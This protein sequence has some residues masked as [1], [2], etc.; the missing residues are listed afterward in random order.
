MVPSGRHFK[1]AATRLPTLKTRSASQPAERKEQVQNDEIFSI[2]VKRQMQMRKDL[3]QLRTPVALPRNK[4]LSSSPQWCAQLPLSDSPGPEIW[5]TMAFTMSTQPVVAL[6]KMDVDP[7]LLAWLLLDFFVVSALPSSLEW[8]IHCMSWIE[9]DGLTVF[10]RLRP[11]KHLSL[12]Q[13][14]FDKGKTANAGL[15]ILEGARLDLSRAGAAASCDGCSASECALRDCRREAGL[16]N[17]SSK[18]PLLRMDDLEVENS[19][20]GR[21]LTGAGVA[22]GGGGAMGGSRCTITCVYA[23]PLIADLPHSNVDFGRD[24]APTE[25][26]PLGWAVGN[27]WV[28]QTVIGTTHFDWWGEERKAYARAMD[29]AIAQ[30][31]PE[32]LKACDGQQAVP[33]SQHWWSSCHSMGFTACRETNL[34]GKCCCPTGQRVGEDGCKSCGVLEERLSALHQLNLLYTLDDP[35]AGQYFFYWM[36]FG[37]LVLLPLPWALLAQVLWQFAEP[38]ESFLQHEAREERKHIA[39]T[40]IGTENLHGPSTIHVANMAGE[41]RAIPGFRE[42]SLLV[43]LRRSVAEVFSVEF[44]EIGL[45]FGGQ[46]LSPDLDFKTLGDLGIYD[47]C[48]VSFIQMGAQAS[49]LSVLPFLETMEV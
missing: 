3:A 37:S 11:E 30:Q 10:M 44:P 8:T 49:V 25:G 18:I 31:L 40:W 45:A 24:T 42:T 38:N 47:G 19:E 6:A 43:H 16:S 14:E 34:A 13:F 7:Y 1:L 9:F 33:D 5:V 48:T 12:A 20:V 21:R 46:L 2:M 29:N 15:V 41:S 28:P 39:E 23:V 27:S 35:D 4:L 36:L 26:F 17:V 32:R 22:G